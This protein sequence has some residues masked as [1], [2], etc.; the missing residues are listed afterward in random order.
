MLC[1]SMDHLVGR[2]TVLPRV[3]S[4]FSM[5]NSS[6]LQE[7]PHSLRH[8]ML[9]PQEAVLHRIKDIA[10]DFKNDRANA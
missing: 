2:H 8:V 3:A 10:W 1:N 6:P 7:L 5:G 4:L 9:S